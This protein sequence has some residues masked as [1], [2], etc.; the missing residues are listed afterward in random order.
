RAVRF[1]LPRRQPR[2]QGPQRCESL[3]PL[4]VEQLQVRLIRQPTVVEA[5][6][7]PPAQYRAASLVQLDVDLARHEALRLLE[8]TLK[9]PADIVKPPPHVRQLGVTPAERFLH[10][11]QLAALHEIFQVAVGRKQNGRRR[12]LI[13]LAALDAQEA[14]L[15]DVAAADAVQAAQAV[16]LAHQRQRLQG[17]AVQAARNPL[18]KAD[19]ED[20]RLVGGLFGR[21]G[22]N[23]GIGGRRLPRIAQV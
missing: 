4:I 11:N 7:T 18:L 16:Q 3:R 19:A 23:E 9:R 22:Q 1:L 8:E 13:K 15:D 14:V 20:R 10:L 6:R 12:R 21:S 17:L 5:V 2:R